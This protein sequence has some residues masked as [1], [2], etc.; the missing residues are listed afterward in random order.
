MANHHA[1]PVKPRPQL[2]SIVHVAD[3]MAHQVGSSPGIGS[4]AAR[5]DEAAIE[6]LGLGPVEIQ[7]LVVETL[8]ALDAVKEILALA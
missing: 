5:P 6:A 3:I 2:S 1:P 8:D 4:F 7:N